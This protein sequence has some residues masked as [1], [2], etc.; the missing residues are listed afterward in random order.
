MPHLAVERAMAEKPPEDAAGCAGA[1]AEPG[2]AAGAAAAD[3][4]E[5]ALGQLGAFKLYQRYMLL[6]LCIPN[7]FAAMYSLNYVFVADAVPFR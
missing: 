6:M 3:A 5:A 2:R 7:L 1:G 4:L